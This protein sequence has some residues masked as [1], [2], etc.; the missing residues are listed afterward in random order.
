MLLQGFEILNQDNGA[1]M[2]LLVNLI[3]K[4]GPKRVSA[5]EA[6]LSPAMNDTAILAPAQALKKSFMDDSQDINK[7]AA[8]TGTMIH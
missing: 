3:K 7:N 2:D 8:A 4:K 6:L 5:T 1:L